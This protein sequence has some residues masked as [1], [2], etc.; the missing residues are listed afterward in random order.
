[1]APHVGNI[2]PTTWSG[3]I[4]GSAALILLIG[5][6]AAAWRVIYSLCFHPL[7][8]F[9]GPWYTACTSLPLGIAG[10]SRSEPAWLCSLVEKYGKNGTPIRIAP[11]LLLF[12]KARQLRDIYWDAACNTKGG[13]YQH[14]A[15]G[16][17][18]LFTTTGADDH[19]KLRKALGGAFWSVG[20]L[21]K[22]WEG[23]IDEL[24]VN[25]VANRRR[26]EEIGKPVVLSNKTSEFA[27]D[28]MTMVLFTTPWGFVRNDRD[29]R[30]M[31]H[32]WRAGTGLFGLAVRWRFLREV[33]LGS[34]LMR[35]YLLP[36]LTDEWGNGWLMAQGMREI[37][38]RH[39]R[40]SKEK[41]GTDTQRLANMT[42]FIQAGADT[43]GTGLGA[44]LRLIL[45]HPDVLAK[46][47]E[48]I[49]A[50]DTKGVL[51][52]PVV[53]YDEAK[54][55]LP[56]LSACIRESLR[57]HS[58]IPNL[59]SRLVPPGDGKT[60]DGFHIPAGTEMLS[61]AVVV[62]QLDTDAFGPDAAEFRP[63]RWLEG[64]EARAARMEACMYTFGMG[65]R[66]CL[67]KELALMELH[68]LVP[69]VLRRFGVEVLE[70]GQYCACGGIAYLQPGLLVRLTSRG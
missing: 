13:I 42:L 48:E 6:A 53:Q 10:L 39:G 56:Y 41:E 36:K 47:C 3:L 33:V 58:P 22:T 9:P 19:R 34:R 38:N 29:E 25:W 69:E 26:D 40:L 50:A 37:S 55:H 63:A 17:T 64:G 43:T 67:G 32:A 15:I 61:H 4:S 51:S 5:V 14:E 31:L 30:G 60:I 54:Q 49:A 18:S 68:K 11:D 44:T 46:V 2:L 62:Q 57:L 23:R 59:F 24:V 1:M 21:K 65:P 45:K 8:H 28:V 66:G 27:A 70:E 20:T 16:P 12:H 52:N 35:D 7:K